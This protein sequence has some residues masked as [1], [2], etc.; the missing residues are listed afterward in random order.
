MDKESNGFLFYLMVLILFVGFILSFVL[1]ARADMNRYRGVICDT[2]EQI[3]NW[4]T[5]FKGGTDPD[6]ALTLINTAAAN[7]TACG[8]VD[9]IVSR[10]EVEK[11]LILNGE[12]ALIYKL[13]VVAAV[14]PFG[15][16]PIEPAIQYGAGKAPKQDTSM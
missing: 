16:Q 8:M 4:A 5:L 7:P 3:E 13:L 15:P 9:V 10:I 11:E 2:A 1:P 14:T 6:E 12:N